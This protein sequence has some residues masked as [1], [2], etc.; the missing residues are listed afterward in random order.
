MQETIEKSIHSATPTPHTRSRN[1]SQKEVSRDTVKWGKYKS[2]KE[3]SVESQLT[4][5]ANKLG[6]EPAGD[7]ESEGSE[8]SNCSNF[9]DGT[10]TYY[11]NEE[12][13]TNQKY[14]GTIKGGQRHGFGIMHYKNKQIYTGEWNQDTREGRGIYEF[15]G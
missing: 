6:L 7:S 2:H 3:N 9:S 10:G 4:T 11:Y 15:A 8:D 5:T 14:I 1:I 12:H 13:P